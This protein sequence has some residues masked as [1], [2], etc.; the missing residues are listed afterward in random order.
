M[1]KSHHGGIFNRGKYHATHDARSARFSSR[2]FRRSGSTRNATGPTGRHYCQLFSDRVHSR[3]RA[4]P[5]FPACNVHELQRLQP[6]S[7]EQLFLTKSSTC[8]TPFKTC[9][10]AMLL[11]RSQKRLARSSDSTLRNSRTSYGRKS[12][13]RRTAKSI[14][15]LCQWQS[16]PYPSMQF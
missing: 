7:L 2:G 3:L 1:D 14:C 8:R 15:C 11:L 5:I 6:E 9:R 16:R 13:T 4:S 12:R 10:R